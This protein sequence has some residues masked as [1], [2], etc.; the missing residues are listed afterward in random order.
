MNRRLPG[1]SGYELVKS[2]ENCILEHSLASCPSTPPSCCHSRL[3]ISPTDAP[4]PDD[5][6]RW[7][8]RVSI[9]LKPLAKPICRCRHP[10]CLRMCNRLPESGSPLL[11]LFL[12]LPRT[13]RDS[14]AGGV[15][16]HAPQ[17]GRS[18]FLAS[19]GKLR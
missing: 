2:A 12:R 19:D 7:K 18:N 3:F 8:Y 1:I 14:P 10:T 4:R 6:P 11:T 15:G 5:D 13:L 16:R 9:K 17:N